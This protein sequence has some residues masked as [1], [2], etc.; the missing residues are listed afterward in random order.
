LQEKP[1]IY[2]LP[3]YITLQIEYYYRVNCIIPIKEIPAE[4]R[5]LYGALMV[6]NKTPEKLRFYYRKWLRHYSPK[7]FKSYRG[8]GPG[9]CKAP[10][11]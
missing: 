1:S 9:N 5:V 2:N 3:T 4:I 7:I 6:Q 8:C 11:C 10:V